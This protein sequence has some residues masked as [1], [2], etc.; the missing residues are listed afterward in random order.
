MH[1]MTTM[2]TTMSGDA[3][4]QLA[5]IPRNPKMLTL[6]LHVSKKSCKRTIFPN[7][8]YPKATYIQKKV[9]IMI[10]F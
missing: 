7:W 8:S 1:K 10:N 6:P 3:L 5:N 2:C 4:L 9:K